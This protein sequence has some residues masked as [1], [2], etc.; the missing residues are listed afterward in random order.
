LQNEEL[1]F[2]GDDWHKIV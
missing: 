1:T 2:T